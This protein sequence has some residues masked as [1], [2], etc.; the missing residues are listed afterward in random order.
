MGLCYY[1]YLKY[2]IKKPAYL[3]ELENE[4]FEKKKSWSIDKVDF[5]LKYQFNDI[6]LYLVLLSVLASFA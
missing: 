2:R 5:L 4:N 3:H 1:L 6:L